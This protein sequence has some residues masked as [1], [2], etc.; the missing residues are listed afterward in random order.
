MDICLRIGGFSDGV[1]EDE[2]FFIVMW[3]VGASSFQAPER[4]EKLMITV[5]GMHA[6]LR[7]VTRACVRLKVTHVGEFY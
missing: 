4:V 7:W 5:K 6:R 2:N 3:D 1:F